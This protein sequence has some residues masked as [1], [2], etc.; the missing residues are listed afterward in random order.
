MTQRIY[1]ILLLA[2]SILGAPTVSR[3]ADN[4]FCVTN[5]DPGHGHR[6]LW[7]HD[8]YDYEIHSALAEPGQRVCFESEFLAGPG[9]YAKVVVKLYE[10][11][12]QTAGR[13]YA[14]SPVDP[15]PA[16]ASGRVEYCF[17]FDKERFVYLFAPGPC[18]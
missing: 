16:D 10:D 13:A 3:A 1:L 2:S 17:R 9:W 15:G 14:T 11:K 4:A 18:S 7:M 6:I 12:A 5:A 8:D